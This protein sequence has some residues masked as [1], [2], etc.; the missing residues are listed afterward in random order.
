[1]NCVLVG[2]E[3]LRMRAILNDKL[4]KKGEQWIVLV[5]GQERLR[6]LRPATDFTRSVTSGL[7]RII[8]LTT[9]K[10][11]FY[12][13]EESPVF[14]MEYNAVFST[15]IQCHRKGMVYHGIYFLILY[16]TFIFAYLSTYVSIIFKKSQRS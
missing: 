1:M 16:K 6:N 9:H 4:I 5:V 7:K 11:E 3:G 10:P 12:F 14:F 2:Q 8:R 13:T 15:Q